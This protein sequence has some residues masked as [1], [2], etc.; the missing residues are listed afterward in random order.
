MKRANWNL[1]KMFLL[2]ANTAS[3]VRLKSYRCCLWIQALVHKNPCEIILSF[4]VSF[5]FQYSFCEWHN[6]LSFFK[7]SFMSSVPC[8]FLCFFV[9]VFKADNF[10]V[11]HHYCILFVLV[12]TGK[13][14]FWFVFDF[15]FLYFHSIR[16]WLKHWH[17]LRFRC[18]SD[19]GVE[20]VSDI[21][22]LH[23]N[24]LSFGVSGWIYI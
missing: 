12:F 15:D 20:I 5:V 13:K 17:Q 10:K 9:V 2:I 14:S 1:A 8:H 22:Q 7:I 21:F 11:L 19:S 6:E 24:V 18:F 4:I 23:L 16:S 3:P